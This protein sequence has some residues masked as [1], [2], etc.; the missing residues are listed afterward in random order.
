VCEINNI[1]TFEKEEEGKHFVHII[2]LNLKLGPT[3]KAESRS[4]MLDSL[5]GVTVNVQENLPVYFGIVQ[6]T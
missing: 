5:A 6:S 4:I 2:F 1:S 3:L